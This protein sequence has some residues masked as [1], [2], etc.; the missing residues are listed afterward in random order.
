MAVLAT[1]FTSCYKNDI[2][3]GNAL[4]ETFTTVAQIDTVSVQLSTLVLDSFATNT[5]SAFAVGRYSDPYLGAITTKAYA[6]LTIPDNVSLENNALYDSLVLMIR[7]NGQ[8]YGDTA[9][10]QTFEVHELDDQPDYVYGTSIFNTTAVAEKPVLLG[11]RT[12]ALRPNRD[13]SISI[14]LSDVKGR[15]L[16][17]LLQNVDEAVSTSASFLNYFNGISVGVA[18]SDSGAVYGFSAAGD[19]LVVRLYYHTNNPYP[20]QHYKSFAFL[21]NGKSFNHITTARQGTALASATA[22][23]QT[24]LL[25]SE[26]GNVSFLQS[27]AGVLLKATF[28]TLRN[29]LQLSSFV[30]LVSATLVI[31]PAEGSFSNYPY[32]LPSALFLV[33]TNGT[34]NLGSPIYNAAGDA[35]LAAY[36]VTDPYYSGG[37]AYGFDVTSIINTLLNTSGS[38]DNGLFILDGYAGTNRQFNRMVAADGSGNGLRIQ[39]LLTV[40]TLKN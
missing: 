2:E 26:T 13:D 1:L 34:N 40:M 4:G 18:A 19:S 38:Q 29:L 6:Q 24:E 27:G 39:L 3:F 35:L 36:P 9:K 33:S 5:G 30:K 37:T 11:S 21:S 17:S 28:P 15:E 8:Y 14:K 32:A 7:P 31:R 10:A 25:S 22:G 16:F 20:Q 23:K 12:A